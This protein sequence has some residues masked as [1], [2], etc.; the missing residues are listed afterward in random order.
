MMNPY[1][2][3]KNFII[4]G[5]HGW[6]PQDIW[7]F[8]HY[9]ANMTAEGTKYL[10]EHQHGHPASLTEKEWRQK[11]K[12][13]IWAFEYYRDERQKFGFRMLVGLGHSKLH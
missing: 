1:R 4:R 12:E 7:S 2:K 13:I 6:C 8:D 9:L 10:M 11:L 5:I 3:I